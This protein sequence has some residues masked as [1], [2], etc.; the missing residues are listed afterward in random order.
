MTHSSSRCSVTVTLCDASVT[1][2]FSRY[3]RVLRA[4]GDSNWMGASIASA[5]SA[6][7]AAVMPLSAM[8]RIAEAVRLNGVGPCQ[9][10]RSGIGKSLVLAPLVWPTLWAAGSRKPAARPPYVLRFR[11]LCKRPLG[12]SKLVHNAPP[13]STEVAHRLRR[14]YRLGQASAAG[15]WALRQLS[16]SAET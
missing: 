15:S 13:A 16:E 9:G 12:P 11:T 1:A 5:M 10:A 7:S 4:P 6:M 2:F 14:R 3:F 8:A